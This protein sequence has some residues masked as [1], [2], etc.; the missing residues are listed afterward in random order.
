M[1]KTDTEKLKEA[2]KKLKEAER[3][4]KEGKGKLM[5]AENVLVGYAVATIVLVIFFIVALACA[6]AYGVKFTNCEKGRV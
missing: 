2:E 3:K 6:I 1:D 4:L 5:R